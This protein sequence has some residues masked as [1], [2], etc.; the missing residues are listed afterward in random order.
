MK[1]INFLKTIQSILLGVL[2]FSIPCLISFKETKDYNDANEIRNTC[3]ETSSEE[4]DC[5]KVLDTFE[6]STMETIDGVTTFEGY[7]TIS[8]DDLLIDE[9]NYSEEEETQVVKVKYNFYYDDNTNMVI[10]TANLI[11]EDGISCEDKMEGVAFVNNEGNI[12]AIFEVDDDYILLSEMQ[13][14]G[15]IQNCGWFKRLAKKIFK[16]V[17][18]VVAVA[19][20]AA[21][22]VAT[23][24]AG[25]GAVIAAGAIA[26]CV[27][28]GIAG[29]VI[30][31]SEYGKLDWRWIVGGMVVGAA[32]G[33]LTGWAVGSIM[34]APTSSEYSFLKKDFK[35]SDTV[36]NH[37]DRPY[38]NSQL[39]AKEIMKSGKPYADPG[40]IPGGLKW[41]VPGS[42][43]GTLGTWEIVYDV[44]K[45]II[46]HF[47]FRA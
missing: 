38:R 24:G 10:L 2:L 12:D 45:N 35:F 14:M 26:G 33:A 4:M 40:G 44:A 19:A 7:K 18:A 30:S 36:S 20:V 27:T 15:M 25:M 11:K 31:K 16:A 5:Y 21:I 28:G 8:I 39:L 37:T 1:K 3:I 41:E 32:L 9:V 46:V 42:Y 22:V 23:A 29:G 34:K 6:E 47:L 17:V 13:E 43:N